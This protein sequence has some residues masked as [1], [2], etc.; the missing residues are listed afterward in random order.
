MI[1]ITPPMPK[2]TTKGD[3][4]LTSG[5]PLVDSFEIVLVV[6]V[7][8]I[9]VLVCVSVEVVV[10]VVVVVVVPPTGIVSPT[11]TVLPANTLPKRT[12][13]IASVS[14]FLVMEGLG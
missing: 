14:M 12:S 11:L 9:V 1:L 5:K 6:L 10:E 4:A 2:P 8:L 7:M 13:S 3:T